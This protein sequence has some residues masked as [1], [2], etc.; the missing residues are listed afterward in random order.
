MEGCGKGG[1]VNIIYA[2]ND[3]YACHLGASLCSLLENN[4]RIPRLDVYVLSVGM[5]EEFQKRL[6]KLGKRYGREVHVMELGGLRR[7]FPYAVDTRGFDISAMA[8]LFAP[9]VLPKP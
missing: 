1:P 2:S 8:R 5:K 7:R 9:E 3:G 4:R 6:Q